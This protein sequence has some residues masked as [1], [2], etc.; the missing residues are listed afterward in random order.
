MTFRDIPVPPVLA[1]GSVLVATL[2]QKIWPL[3]RLWQHPA[4]TVGGGLLLVVG[5]GIWAVTLRMFRVRQTTLNPVGKPTT[6]ILTGAYRF[7]RNPLYVAGVLLL[8]AIFVLTALPY[9]AMGPVVFAW[10]I[11]GWV[12]PREE[13]N[14][15]EQFGAAYGDYCAR[16]RRWL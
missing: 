3:E 14:L 7:S 9:F 10:I 4:M 1:V 2:L 5:V 15:R 8:L 16:V 13:A 12:I 6:L 11:N